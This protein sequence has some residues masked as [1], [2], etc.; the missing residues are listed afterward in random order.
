MRRGFTRALQHEAAVEAL[1]PAVPVLLEAGGYC[2]SLKQ[3]GVFFG[4]LGGFLLELQASRT[5]VSPTGT[6]A[7]S[8]AASRLLL[9]A[10]VV[11]RSKRAVG[12]QKPFVLARRRQEERPKASWR[13]SCTRRRQ[14]AGRRS[15]QA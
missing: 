15:V 10:R 12:H 1:Q 14:R 7:C 3:H 8:G 11:V 9:H 4:G 2:A 13:T 5:A 6:Q